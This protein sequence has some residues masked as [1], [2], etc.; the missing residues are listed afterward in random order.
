MGQRT[1]S[2]TWMT[3]KP[4]VVY[5]VPSV[6]PHVYATAMGRL[7]NSVQADLGWEPGSIELIGLIAA[8]AEHG[9][10]GIY[11]L[12]EMGVDTRSLTL[13]VLWGETAEAVKFEDRVSEECGIGGVVLPETGVVIPTVRMPSVDSDWW[14]DPLHQAFAAVTYAGLVQDG[15]SQL[16][17]DPYV[18]IAGPH[19]WN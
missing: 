1:Q 5:M 9:T 6:R 15:R 12:E 3:N 17:G 2:R 11:F 19:T 18:F 14:N 13:L 10:E 8:T 4:T 7:T 16:D